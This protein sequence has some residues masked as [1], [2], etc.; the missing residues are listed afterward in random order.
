MPT[1]ISIFHYY[2]QKNYF[3]KNACS[4][5]PD[6][7]LNTLLTEDFRQKHSV[8]CVTIRSFS[9]QGFPINGLNTEIHRTGRVNAMKVRKVSTGLYHD[10]SWWYTSKKAH[11]IWVSACWL[12]I[13][14]SLCDSG[15]SKSF[16]KWRMVSQKN[17]QTRT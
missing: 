16:N 9:V 1:F 8:K 10:D 4:F 13:F 14:Y 7:V 17:K 3:C 15:L 5:M 2:L 12:K 6:K 11:C